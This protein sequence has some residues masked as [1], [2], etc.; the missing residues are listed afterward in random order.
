MNKQNNKKYLDDIEKRLE[1]KTGRREK[2][3]GKKMKV[4]SAGVKTLEK[5]IINK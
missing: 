1:K 3:R 2:K 5:I 4:D